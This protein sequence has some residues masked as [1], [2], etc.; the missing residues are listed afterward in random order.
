MFTLW[1]QQPAAEMSLIIVEGNISAGKSSLCRSLAGLLGFELFLE[2]TV[3]NPF[4]AKFYKDPKKWALRMQ[5]W[6]LKQRFR[7]YISA[8]RHIIATGKGAI[9]DRSIYSDWVFAERNRL[10]GN[11]SEEG[12]AYYQALRD[13]MLLQLPTPH[14]MVTPPFF[15]HPH[16]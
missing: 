10:D 4:L 15:Q 8:I 1:P 3:T 9:L 6:L 7:T 5:I 14:A 16:L 12:F 11:I 13:Q 2:P